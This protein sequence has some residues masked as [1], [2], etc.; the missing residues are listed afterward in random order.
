[1][2]TIDRDELKGLMHQHQNLVIVDVLPPEKFKEFHIPGAVNVPLG[3]GF[4]ELI[5]SAV[6]DKAVPVVVYCEDAACD[7]S[8]KAAARMEVLGYAKVH[9]YEGGKV[10][11]RDAGMPI[12]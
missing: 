4:D 9:D 2:R 11:W 3:K 7:A 1:M 10:D 8:P 6:P 12:N 5:Q